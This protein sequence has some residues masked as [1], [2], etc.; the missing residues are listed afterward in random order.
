MNEPSNFYNGFLN[1]CPWNDLD[2][3]EYVPQI[4]GG[5]LAR[6]TLCMNS[7]HYLGA[8]YDRSELESL[9]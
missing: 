3:P 2:N 4:N 1:G 7:Q 8:H 5:I 9:A 6:K